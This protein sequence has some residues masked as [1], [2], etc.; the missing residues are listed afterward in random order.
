LKNEKETE[1]EYGATGKA[2]LIK[3]MY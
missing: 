2:K 1:M 3:K